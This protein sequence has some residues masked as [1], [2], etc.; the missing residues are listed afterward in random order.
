[1]QEDQLPPPP[2][3]L[4]APVRGY[5]ASARP[6]PS[7]QERDALVRRGLP[8]V[9]RLAFRM[10]RR[11]P[12]SVEVGDLIGA[13][14][15]GL[16]KAAASYDG[17][18]H[19]RF[20]PYAEARIRGAMLDELRSADPVTRHGR[21][22]MSEVSKAIAALTQR[23]GRPPEEAEVADE[24]GMTLE[25]YRK[26]SEDL[27]KAPALGHVGD[28]LPDEIQ[29]DAED[30]A[31]VY[32]E[33]ERQR[34]VADAI[35]RLPQRTQMVLALY[36]QE[37]CTQAEIGRILEVTEGRVCQILGEAAARIRAELGLEAKKKRKRRKPSS[38]RKN[39]D[40]GP[41]DRGAS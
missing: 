39:P 23:Y 1:M 21:Q 10:A 19:P 31:S 20:E 37:E 35:T 11:L 13:G 28:V 27:A 26:L 6:A 4:R 3:L 41:N 17:S 22:K 33:K 15:E 16:M 40:D 18:K 8:I 32:L 5:G 36:Y 12:A 9:R 24:L 2:P 7:R 14:S 34:L 25:R 30:P 29:G 38:G